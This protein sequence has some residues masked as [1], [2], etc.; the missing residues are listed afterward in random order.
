MPKIRAFFPQLGHFFPIFKKGQ[1]RSPHLQLRA[2]RM[3]DFLIIHQ[4][5]SLCRERCQLHI[6][7][8]NLFL[9]EQFIRVQVSTSFITRL[10]NVVAKSSDPIHY[11]YQLSSDLYIVWRIFGLPSCLLKQLE[12]LFPLFLDFLHSTDHFFGLGFIFLVIHNN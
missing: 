2:C 11:L 4:L 8:N 7:Y 12:H 5:L 6:F 1:G 9:I 10:I 3:I